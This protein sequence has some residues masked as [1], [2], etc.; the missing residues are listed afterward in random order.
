M[1]PTQLSDVLNRQVEEICR[2][3]LPQGKRVGKDWVAG[4]CFG[5][6]GKSLK[7]VLDGAKVGVWCDFHT[8]ESGGDLIDLWRI[9]F[10][11]SMMEAMKQSAA[12]VGVV[13]AGWES[14]PERRY[15]RPERPRNARK[16]KEGGKVFTYLTEARRI[17]PETLET[18]QIGEQ[19][20]EWILFPYKRDGQLLNTKYLHLERDEKGKK[21]IRQETG[22]EPSLFGWHVLD[23]KYPG[24]RYVA[25]VE[26]EVDCM[27]L[28]QCGIPSLSVPNGGGG[29]KKQDW[30]ESDYDHLN[31]FDTIFLC[32]DNDDAGK[33]AADAII[34]RLGSERCKVVS[35]PY[36]DANE[37]LMNGI[38]QFN[39]YFLRART[40]DPA[41]LKP[42]DSF[43]DSVLDKFYPQPGS[44]QGMKTPWAKLNEAMTF[45]RSE[46]I[47]WT[48]FSGSGKSQI[49]GQMA[50]HGMQ[51]NERF[52]IC[53][54]E[55]PSRVTLWRMVRQITGQEKPLPEDVK[56]AMAWLKD[57]LW[58]IDVVGKMKTERILEVFRYAAKRYNIRHFVLDSLTKCHIR[59]D[60]Y[61]GQ[62]EFIDALCDFNHQYEATTHLVVHQRKPDGDYRRPDK[63]GVRGASAITDE[64]STVLSIYRVP[65]QDDEPKQPKR[66]GAAPKDESYIPHNT[67]LS[68][69]KNRET[70]IEGKFGLYFDPQ[71]LQFHEEQ[72]PSVSYLVEAHDDGTF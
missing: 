13:L 46:L 63:I 64:A 3:L 25:L 21:R 53:S 52:A 57:K 71:S 70:G 55:M 68:V 24:T 26:G 56:K 59:E 27:T 48:G 7:V 43:L 17:L 34:Q 47:I 45:N 29:G 42:A 8:G 49:L 37:C 60:D 11:V 22:A 39:D 61:D 36:K 19:E 9:H 69:V 5:S 41:E 33:Q 54:L 40:F 1:T 32:L 16:P 35:L 66:K 4:D 65:E 6:P 31:R 18:F 44:Y 58:M 50:I 72:Q 15:N 2:F 12:H 10:G 20:D 14:R 28:H 62:K 30:I 67:I 51:Q 38:Y 23:A